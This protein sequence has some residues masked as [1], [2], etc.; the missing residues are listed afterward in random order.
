MYLNYCEV[1][2]P[3]LDVFKDRDSIV[4]DNNI[5]PQRHYNADFMIKFGP[6]TPKLYYWLRKFVFRV[7]CALHPVAKHIPTNK[8]SAGMIPVAKFNFDK[9]NF[10]DCTRAQV[11]YALK[12]FSEV[13]HVRCI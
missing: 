10:T 8:L 2:K 3:L 13:K 11:V 6:S 9:S 1:G 12:E 5:K 4:G 7:W